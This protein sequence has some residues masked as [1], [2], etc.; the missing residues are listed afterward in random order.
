MKTLVILVLVAVGAAPCLFAQPLE[1]GWFGGIGVGI[2]AHDNGPFSN[3][4]QSWSPIGERGR[5]RVYRSAPVPSTGYTLNAGGAV[6]LSEKVLL[7]ASGELLFFPSF[8]AITTEEERSVYSLS[9]L[10]GGLDFG[11]AIVN[12]GGTLVWPFVSAGYYGYTL[13]FENNQTEPT[14]FFEGDPVEPGATET[15][16]GA[17]FRGGLGVGFTR[18]LGGGTSGELSG[19]VL[20]MRLT[21]GRY[22]S[23]PSWSANGEE[24]TN[25]GH[26]PC[27]NA[28]S[29]S[30]MIGG[31]TGR[32]E[33]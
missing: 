4:L 17:S 3:R 28:L 21:W 16:D 30:V 11:Y 22:L 2:G 12:D 8:E 6:L 9:G 10:G 5:E 33:N 7:G 24:V 15:Y 14:P 31:G 20:Q 25:G 26:T 29:L 32:I 13:D 1:S 19:L 23:H 27:Y 18:Y